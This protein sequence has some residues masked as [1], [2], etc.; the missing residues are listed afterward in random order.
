M[1][2]FYESNESFKHYV[3][4][5]CVKHQIT[6][7]QAFEVMLVKYYAEYLRK[8]AEGKIITTTKLTG[9]GC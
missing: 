2:E 3:D 1:N 5:Y 6:K 7:E 4:R 9:S 8:S